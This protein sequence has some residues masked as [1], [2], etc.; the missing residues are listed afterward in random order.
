MS[1]LVHLG[2]AV[3]H[4]KQLKLVLAERI[5]FSTTQKVVVV[6]VAVSLGLL[7]IA[8]SMK[9]KKQ[10]VDPTK[11][12]RQL[13]RRLRSSGVRSPNGDVI[14]L[15]S[16]GRKSLSYSTY[17]DK[18]HN[19]VAAVGSEKGA[20]SVAS[21]GSLIAGDGGV[22]THLSPQ[23]LGVMGMEAL[24]TS[25][26]YWEDALAAYRSNDKGGPLA[27]LGPEEAA[28]C[29]DLQ[30]LL[31]A[32]LELQER[33]ELLFLDERSVLFHPG[34]GA[35]KSQKG[36]DGDLSGAESFASAQDQVADLREFEEF[37]EIF[38][39]VEKLPLYQAALVQLED[40]GIPCRSLRTE[41]VK[42]GSDSEYLAKLHCLRLAFQHM[43][44]D[45][46]VY[47]WFV[48]SGR[49]I[50]ADLLLYADKD[51]K[52][53]LM[54]YEEMLKFLQ[55]SVNW[56]DVETELSL[57]GVKA[58]TFYDVVLDYILMDAFEDLESPPMSVTAVVQNRWLSNGF[59]ET[60]LTTALW[61]IL[62]AK[63]RMLKFPAG[64]M[65]HFYT[66]MEQLSPLL[67]WG[68]LGPDESLRDTCFFFKEQVMGFLVDIFNFQKCKYTTVEELS[69]DVLNNIRHRVDLISQRLSVQA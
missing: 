50:L 61:S 33:S 4:I 43:L 17:S 45:K 37:S 1:L 49:Q 47:L 24:E 6:S 36:V 25:I 52:D 64:F 7:G 9:R 53:F 63:R 66:L 56:R 65:S 67:A 42:C 12:R 40:G 10:T 29:R 35:P 5:S 16:S 46:T 55:T 30:L 44:R 38:P 68:F 3:D 59:K 57:K 31:E 15:A 14:S 39:D 2:S 22:T 20:G 8:R 21:G 13:G 11:Y 58:L 27:V 48:N 62:K 19:S 18:R 34:S 28:F 41:I 26:N 60:A 69:N 51:P 54:G 23:Q 32:A